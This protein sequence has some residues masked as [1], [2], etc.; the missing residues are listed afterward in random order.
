[1][2]DANSKVFQRSHRQKGTAEETLFMCKKY[3]NHFFQDSTS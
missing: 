2:F 1:M 3:M